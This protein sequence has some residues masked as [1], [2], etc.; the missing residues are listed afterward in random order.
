MNLQ[1]LIISLSLSVIAGQY[2]FHRTHRAVCDRKK[3]CNG[4]LMCAYVCEKGSVIVD[5]WVVSLLF[6][7]NL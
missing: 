4:N 7:Y 3:V 6:I 2:Q 1:I 5:P